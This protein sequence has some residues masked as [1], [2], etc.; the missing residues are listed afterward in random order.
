MYSKPLFFT[1]RCTS[2]TSFETEAVGVPKGIKQKSARHFFGVAMV[3]ED[4]DSGTLV[5]AALA[6]VSPVKLSAILVQLLRD[7]RYP[8]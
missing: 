1:I 5:S 7:L 8:T 6:I 3:S 4:L 2:A